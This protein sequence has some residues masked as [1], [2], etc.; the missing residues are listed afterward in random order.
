MTN[1]TLPT[2]AAQ[3]DADTPNFSWSRHWYPVAYLK[4]LDPARP[5]AFTLLGEDPLVL[6][7]DR[8]ENQWRA[9]ADV[10]PHRLVPLSEGR[11]N[12]SGNLECP[13]H[14]WSFNGEG[15]CTTIPQ[16]PPATERAEPSAEGLEARL[17]S[18]RSRCRTYA[19]ACGQGLLFV[20]AGDS[21]RGR[22]GPI[23][24]GAPPD[25]GGGCLVCSGHLS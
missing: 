22:G 21:G 8:Q 24:V 7:W 25:G 1:T 5:T 12:E 14:G 23:A 6:W 18:P 9:F 10:C 11:I 13:Y 3:A 16:A 19:T 20:F 17:A 15:H 4:D 2:P